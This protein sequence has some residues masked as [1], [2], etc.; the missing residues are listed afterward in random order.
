MSIHHRLKN[1][2]VMITGASSGIGYST[3]L[4]FAAEGAH[5][6]LGARRCDKMKDLARLAHERYDVRVF[7]HPLDVCSTQSVTAFVEAAVVEFG[8]IDIL[9]NN[10]GLALGIAKVSEGSDDDW[11]TMLDT[12]V[13]GVLRVTRAM[14][15]HLTKQAAGH[16]INLGSLAGHISY[17]GG[18]VYAGTKHALRAI[19]EALRHEL[20]GQPIRVTSIDPGLVETEFSQIRF[21]GDADRAKKV[22]SG[23]SPLTAE[24]IAECVIFA[25]SRPTHVNIDTMIVTSIDQAGMNVHRRS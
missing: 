23:I 2:V 6:A 24:D 10:A 5:L 12:N 20:L 4:A 7:T 19:S 9:V 14:L 8:N 15:P 13:M 21:K 16:I 11:M 1:K 17:P 18:S 3:A 22:Y 25:A